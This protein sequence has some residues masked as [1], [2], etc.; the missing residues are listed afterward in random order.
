MKTYKHLFFDLDRTLWHFDRNSEETL[1]EIILEQRLHDYGVSD[2]TAFIREY[3]KINEMCWAQYRKGELDKESLRVIR[4]SRVLEQHG[5]HAPGMA[6]RMADRYVEVSPT[7][8]V[9][10][11]GAMDVLEYLKGR[12]YVMHIITNGFEEVQFVKLNNSGLSPFFQ[13]VIIS[14]RIGFKKP[15]P[16]AFEFALRTSGALQDES[17][18]IGDDLEADVGGAR[19]AGIDQIYYN[20]E[21]LTHEEVITHEIAHLHELRDLL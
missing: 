14:E 18:V 11:D 4:F 2:S 16:K 9:L 6:E 5:V 13:E 19:K 15:H 12:G 20:P 17:I 7:K 21:R 3:R 10:C 1:Q 8:T